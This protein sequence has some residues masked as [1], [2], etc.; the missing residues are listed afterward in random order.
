MTM[1]WQPVVAAL[2]NARLREVYAGAVLGADVGATETELSRLAEAG[3]LDPQDNAV[4]EGIFAALLESGA[5]PR[6]E[7]VEKYFAAGMLTRLPAGPAAR[8]EVLA[9]LAERLLP[10]EDVLSEVD[11]NRL[12]ATVTDDVPMLRRALVDHGYLWRNADGSQYMV[13]R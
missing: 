10:G 9:H 1:P 4:A 8:E 11:I 5:T 7:G 2:A 3:L 13:R 12:L 6:P